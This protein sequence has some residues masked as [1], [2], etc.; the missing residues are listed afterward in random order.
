MFDSHAHVAFNKF[1]SDREAVIE[2]ALVAGVTGWI[3]IGADMDSTRKAVALAEKYDRAFAT[4]GVHPDDIKELN[5]DTWKEL[6]VL[7]K[8]DKAVAIGEVGF[9]YFTGGKH[10][11]QEPVLRRFI[12]MAVS[13]DKSVVFHMRSGGGRDANED[14]LSLLNCLSD[15]Q[16]SRGVLH[17]YSG[18]VA[19][20]EDFLKLGLYFGISGIVTFKNSGELPE[21]VRLVPLDR[22]LVETDCPFLAPE[23]FR[24][25]RNELA[26]V[27]YVVER[28]AEIK[29]LSFSEVEK[30][31]EENARRLFGICD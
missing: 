30:V 17:T 6:E 28:V 22:I 10:A 3:E 23:P 16:R 12:A 26:Y 25:K 1:D 7:A 8:H 13:L 9:D 14:L 11:E 27:K 2:R 5:E 20:A 18:T 19:Q 21:V 29:G 31:T 4:V 24:G 15:R